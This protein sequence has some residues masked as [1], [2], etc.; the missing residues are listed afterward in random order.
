MKQRLTTGDEHNLTDNNTIRSQCPIPKLKDDEDGRLV[1]DAGM[2]EWEKSVM[3]G[4]GI[5]DKNVAIKIVTDAART[6]HPDLE[7][8]TDSVNT[9]LTLMHGINPQDEQEGMLAAQIISSHNMAMQC[10]IRASS[11]GQPAE[12]IDLFTKLATKLMR[13]YTAALEALTR[14]RGKGQQKISVEHVHVHKGG[15]AIVGDVH[16]QG[17]GDH[18]K[19][20]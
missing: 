12:G 13:S 10:F 5:P 4:T 6:I 8:F 18:G 19:K 3:R 2:E 9:C 7:K 1:C 15:Q 11:Q 14:Y 16:H 17:G 20:Q